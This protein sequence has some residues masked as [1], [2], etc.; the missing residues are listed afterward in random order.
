[1]L[2]REGTIVENVLSLVITHLLSEDSGMLNRVSDDRHLFHMFSRNAQSSV[3]Y[4]IF[5]SLSKQK[6]FSFHESNRLKIL[7]PLKGNYYVKVCKPVDHV[8]FF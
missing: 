7:Q 4:K 8:L 3:I 2:Y 6:L 1:M 5:S